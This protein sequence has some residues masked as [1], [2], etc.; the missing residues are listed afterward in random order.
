MARDARDR[1]RTP[2][3]VGSPFREGATPYRPNNTKGLCV[4]STCEPAS[5]S[6]RSTRFLVPANS[7]TT[8]GRTIRGRS[9]ATPASGRRSAV[10]EEL[11]LVYLPVE[12]PTTDYY[13]GHRPGNNLFA[14]SLVALDLKTGQRKWHYQLV[15]HP[16]W[17]FDMSSAADSRR[18]QRGRSRDQSG[19]RCRQTG[20][21]VCVRSRH[22]SAG[23]ADRGTS[24]A[25]KRRA[26]REDDPDAALPDQAAGLHAGTFSS[27][28][29]I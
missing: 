26:R 21:P 10:D 19:G 2:S 7:A 12:T 17:N 20:I 5:C 9:T 29:T 16:L 13:G 18:H 24:G 27:S 22:R 11:G 23:V 15:H 3:I 28:P 8:P 1:A 14:E 4:R 25:R 6:G